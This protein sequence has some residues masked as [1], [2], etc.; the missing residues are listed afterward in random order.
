MDPVFIIQH[1]D[2]NPPGSIARYLTLAGL[3]FEVR[4]VGRG[5]PLPSSPSE[6]S[7]LIVLGGDMNTHQNDQFPF[8]QIE[9]DLMLTCLRTEAPLLGICL[10]AQQLAVAAARS[11]RSGGSRSTSSRRTR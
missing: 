8:L 6:F 4:H 2:A 7:A 10:G 9:R 1:E 11:R 3:P 5:D